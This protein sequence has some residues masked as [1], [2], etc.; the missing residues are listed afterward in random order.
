MTLLCK[1]YNLAGK[2]PHAQDFEKNTR[3]RSIVINRFRE[4]S[5]NHLNVH[6]YYRLVTG[7]R[8]WA[9]NDSKNCIEGEAGT[10]FAI[11][12]ESSIRGGGSTRVLVRV[13]VVIDKNMEIRRVSIHSFIQYC[14]YFTDSYLLIHSSHVCIYIHSYMYILDN[15]HV[16]TTYHYYM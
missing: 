10:T 5:K 2:H 13:N 4:G 14:T 1:F 8:K 7:S 3:D 15:I 16:C 12:R 9:F 6:Y 11:W